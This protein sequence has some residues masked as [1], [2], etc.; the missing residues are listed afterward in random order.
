MDVMRRILRRLSRVQNLTDSISAFRGIFEARLATA[1]AEARGKLTALAANSF[2]FCTVPN[3]STVFVPA[4]VR[5]VATARP[6]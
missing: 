5:S 1:A 2:H 4:W 3:F 6:S